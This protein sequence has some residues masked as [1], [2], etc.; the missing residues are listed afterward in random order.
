M[1]FGAY[2][3]GMPQ[4]AAATATFSLRGTGL[5]ESETVAYVEAIAWTG[6]NASILS[7][8]AVEGGRLSY[9]AFAP[10]AIHFDVPSHAHK[11]ELRVYWTGVGSV[12]VDRIDLVAD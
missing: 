2:E 12:W 8:D 7:Q 3:T 5:P 6:T 10:I 1:V 9:G 4:G 11:I